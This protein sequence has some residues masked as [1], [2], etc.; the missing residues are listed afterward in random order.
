MGPHFC[1][2]KHT[3]PVFVCGKN[4]KA[5]QWAHTKTNSLYFRKCG[6]ENHTEKLL[7]SVSKNE[8]HTKVIFN[9]ER[10]N[11]GGE[12]QTKRQTDRQRETDRDRQR[13]TETDRQADMSSKRRR[14]IGCIAV[15]LATVAIVTSAS[16]SDSRAPYEQNKPPVEDWWSTSWGKLVRSVDVANPTSYAGRTFRK[17]FR[18]PFRLSSISSTPVGSIV[19]SEASVRPLESQRCQ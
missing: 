10:Q 3:K 4:C 8:P 11:P 16:A 5:A 14:L 17:R 15:V 19:C 1:R 18:L 13:Q 9:K 12:R 7:F 6:E 2:K